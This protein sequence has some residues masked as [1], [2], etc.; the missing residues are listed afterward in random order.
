[1]AI[2]HRKFCNYLLHFFRLQFRTSI[3]GKQQGATYTSEQYGGIVFHTP[4]E[5]SGAAGARLTEI[6]WFAQ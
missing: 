3:A 5:P 2:L 4:V 1:M 6:T